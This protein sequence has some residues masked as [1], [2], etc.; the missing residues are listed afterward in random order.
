M[1]TLSVEA[2][3]DETARMVESVIVLRLATKHINLWMRQLE[4]KKRE[5]IELAGLMGFDDVRN[6]IEKQKSMEWWA[7]RCSTHFTKTVRRR[8]YEEIDNMV[9]NDGGGEI[10]RWCQ[11]NKLYDEITETEIEEIWNRDDPSDDEHIRLNKKYVWG[12]AKRVCDFINA[13]DD[14]INITSFCEYRVVMK[15]VIWTINETHNLERKRRQTSRKERSEEYAIRTQKA[16]ALIFNIKRGG[17]RKEEIEQMLE[18]ISGKG[19]VQEIENANTMERSPNES[20]SFQGERSSW[21]R[22]T[23]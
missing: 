14:L 6:G 17:M 7:M 2:L 10:A 1:T 4:M 8:F 13:H 3:D 16:K 12:T 15:K 19:S 22:G 11:R 18:K 9:W 21:K 5:I 23:R 20:K